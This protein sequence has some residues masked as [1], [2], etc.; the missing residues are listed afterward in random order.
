MQR[1]FTFCFMIK[2]HIRTLNK[3]KSESLTVIAWVVVCGIKIKIEF[4]R[5]IATLCK[6]KNVRHVL[7][8]YPSIV[9]HF[10][11][12]GISNKIFLKNAIIFT[13]TIY[14]NWQLY[15]SNFYTHLIYDLKHSFS[16]ERVFQVSEHS[17]LQPSKLIL[18]VTHQHMWWLYHSMIK[19]NYRY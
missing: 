8:A 2:Q 9:R 4:W 15:L 17:L 12:V 10:W 1:N 6:T 7:T 13:P 14:I 11:C 19:T 18:S 16:V 5:K 3:Y